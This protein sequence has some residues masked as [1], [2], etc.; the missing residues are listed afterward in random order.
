MMGIGASCTN[1]WIISQLLS[2]ATT[3]TS[4]TDAAIHARRRERTAHEPLDAGSAVVDGMATMES[5][6]NNVPRRCAM[7]RTHPPERQGYPRWTSA[8]PM[9]VGRF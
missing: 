5:V 9:A 3:F 2:N 6:F 8:R 1:R 4:T 7:R